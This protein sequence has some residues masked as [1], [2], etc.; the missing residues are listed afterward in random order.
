MLQMLCSL[1]GLMGSCMMSLLLGHTGICFHGEG[2]ERHIPG[3]WNR[4]NKGQEVKVVE[5]V[6]KV[7]TP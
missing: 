1:A 7:L 2:K 4:S 5:L 3:N 6:S